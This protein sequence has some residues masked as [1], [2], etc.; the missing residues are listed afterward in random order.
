ML[1]FHRQLR[2]EVI[3]AAQLIQ[4][5]SVVVLEGPD[6][7]PRW[8]TALESRWVLWRFQLALADERSRCFEQE[9]EVAAV[10]MAVVGEEA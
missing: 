2:R 3:L 7:Y 5:E 4:I 9:V 6:S 8:E 1:Q 10:Q